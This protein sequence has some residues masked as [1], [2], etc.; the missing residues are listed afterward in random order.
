MLLSAIDGVTP[1]AETEVT[2]DMDKLAD[3]VPG[4]P[5]P[6]FYYTSTTQQT[7]F[8]CTEC[9]SFNDVRG[10]FA[11]CA[12][13][14]WRNDLAAIKA[15]LSGIRQRLNDKTLVPAEAVRQAIS[16]FDSM[17]RDFA[18]QL[19]APVPMKEYRRNQ[20]KSLLFHN[21]DKV[22]EQLKPAFDIDLL[23]AIGKKRAFVRMM[24][25]PRHAY[26]HDG[27]VMTASICRRKWRPDCP[28]RFYSG[29][30]RTTFTSSS[31]LL[32]AWRKHSM[33]TS[34]RSSR[35]CPSA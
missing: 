34:I 30:Q 25:H 11:Y 29:R 33:L 24:F 7:Q 17:G 22:Q 19:A 2:I 6:D 31:A 8:K 23:R 27:G 9:G 28:R 16:E 12:S 18:T 14:G 15:S 10:K 20:L 26:E 32:N 1:G 4:E 35:Q 3:A 5:R 21:L 13:C